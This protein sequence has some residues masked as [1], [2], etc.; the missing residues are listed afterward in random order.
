MNYKELLR[1]ILQ[2]SK[3][4]VI[5]THLFKDNGDIVSRLN[6]NGFT[7]L[8]L[9]EL[10]EISR[11]TRMVKED[12]SI[13]SEDDFKTIFQD[14]YT[15]YMVKNKLKNIT[16]SGGLSVVYDDLNGK[17]YAI[18]VRPDNIEINSIN[19]IPYTTDELNRR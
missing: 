5:N 10:N 14:A 15:S 4:N 12:C 1:K 9:G 19:H 17:A 18:A 3:M 2:T 8:E 13:N 16:F 11:D 6:E 7:D